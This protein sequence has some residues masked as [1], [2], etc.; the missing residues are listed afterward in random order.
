[1]LNNQDKTNAN[2]NSDSDSETVEDSHAMLLRHY[3]A[4][5]MEQTWLNMQAIKGSADSDVW[6]DAR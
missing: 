4:M 5:L 6:G 2:V 3:H 1:M